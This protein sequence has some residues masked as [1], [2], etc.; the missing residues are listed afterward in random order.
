MGACDT[1]IQPS[2]VVEIRDAETGAAA[3][4]GAT[5]VAVSGSDRLTL[6]PYAMDPDG[7]LLSLATPGE[8]AGN[9]TVRVTKAGYA[10]W[11]REDVRIR[12]RGCHTNQAVLDAR[13]EANGD[14]EAME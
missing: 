8:R 7:V 9:F 10:A 6:E 4:A 5:A 3:A 1:S 2:I 11:E 13:L 14:F 12:D